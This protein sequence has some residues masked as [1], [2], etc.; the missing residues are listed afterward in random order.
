MYGV[1]RSNGWCCIFMGKIRHASYNSR[2]SGFT[3]TISNLLL[4]FHSCILLQNLG[5][6]TSTVKIEDTA[7]VRLP[8]FVV[9]TYIRV[10]PNPRTQIKLC[11]P[12]SRQN[13]YI[14][15]RNC[16]DTVSTQVTTKYAALPN[17]YAYATINTHPCSQIHRT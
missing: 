7:C 17:V 8:V 12:F 3:T 2:S 15:T 13:I 9:C 14:H 11:T 16:D 10:T 6:F 5:F 1:E 4:L